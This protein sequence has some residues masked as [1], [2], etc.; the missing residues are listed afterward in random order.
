MRLI[1]TH[2]LQIEGFSDINKPTY[3]ILS[4]RWITGLELTFQQFIDPAY[5]RTK[6]FEKIAR[7]CDQAREDGF[8]WA[9]AD[10]CCINKAGD[11]T[12]LSEA[13][14]L[15]YEWY[16]DSGRCYVYLSDVS[17]SRQGEL[18]VSEIARSEWFKRAWTLQEL[19]APARLAFYDATWMYIGTK[20]GLA[21]M[22]CGIT[23]IDVDVLSSHRP[24]KSY[25][26]AQRMS[27]AALRQ[28]TRTEDRAYSL[29]GLFDVKLP[30]VYGEGASA[31][32]RLQEEL[33]KRSSDQTLFV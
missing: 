4:N 10:T 31:F 16:R 32:R 6:G 25:S 24:P 7:F 3:A 15:M 2:T 5:R 13:I 18:T 8:E 30:T 1:N 23:R 19:V 21:D 28:S 9:W 17:A 14:N 26:I 12:E 33:M 29:F 11:N 27:W 22:L 20:R